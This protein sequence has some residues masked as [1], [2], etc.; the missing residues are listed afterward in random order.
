MAQFFVITTE[1]H[2]CCY[3]WQQIPP[4]S[5]VI[6]RARSAAGFRMVPGFGKKETY[7]HYP[8]CPPRPTE[9]KEDKHAL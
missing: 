1:V 6:K 3:C 5:Y 8:A 4:G 9:K 7:E 2:D